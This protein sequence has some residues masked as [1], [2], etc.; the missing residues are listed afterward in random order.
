ML[1]GHRLGCA[2]RVCGDVVVDVPPSSQVHRQVV[3]KDL[4]LPPITV[5]PSFTLWYVEVPKLE[6]GEPGDDLTAVSAIGRALVEQH[7]RDADR[8]PSGAVRRAR[9]AAAGARRSRPAR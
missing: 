1:A 8:Q 9:R 5:D 7:G 6:L 4:D 3:R 2:A